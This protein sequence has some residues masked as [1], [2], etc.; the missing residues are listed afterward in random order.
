MF[1]YSALFPRK[2]K[3]QW[4]SHLLLQTQASNVI[5]EGF[6]KKKKGRRDKEKTSAGFQQGGFVSCLSLQ[7][8]CQ[9]PS[10]NTL[11]D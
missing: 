3:H 8:L 6:L 2:T 9:S 11:S 7:D 1:S 5:L 10:L 4:R